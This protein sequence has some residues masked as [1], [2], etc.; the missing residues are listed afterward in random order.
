M[1]VFSTIRFSGTRAWVALLYVCTCAYAQQ[2]DLSEALQPREEFPL[3]LPKLFV[4]ID[5]ETREFDGVRVSLPPDFKDQ[6][7]I[8]TYDDLYIKNTSNGREKTQYRELPEKA[9]FLSKFEAKYLIKVNTCF[10]SALED[11]EKLL[12]KN[13]WGRCLYFDA[14]FPH[15]LSGYYSLV[16]AARNSESALPFGARVPEEAFDVS[17]CSPKTDA[18]INRWKGSLDTIIK[19][20]IASKELANQLK[21]W[22]K[23]LDKIKDNEDAVTPKE[24]EDALVVF[25][26]VY[27]GLKPSSTAVVKKRKRL[28]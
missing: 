11:F 19:L 24:M 17:Q 14:Y 13:N 18:R 16:G 3:E 25:V 6:V 5:D 28:Y 27:F 23:S 8:G 10:L 20:R 26:R 12:Q 21:A 2:L 7:F 9:A 15:F 1:A 4:S 22:G